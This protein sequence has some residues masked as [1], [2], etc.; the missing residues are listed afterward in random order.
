MIDEYYKNDL[1]NLK[2]HVILIPNP[3]A[4]PQF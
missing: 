1:T 4:G 3:R 2:K